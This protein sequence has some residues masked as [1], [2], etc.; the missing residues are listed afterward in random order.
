MR[1]AD[2]G[3]IRFRQLLTSLFIL[4]SLSIVMPGKVIERIPIPSSSAGTE[5]FLAVHRW[6]PSKPSTN[7]GG[8]LYIQAALHA[9]ETPGILVAQQLIS[10]LDAADARG[11]IARE[12]IIVPFANPIGL[13]QNILGSHIGVGIILPA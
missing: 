6:T 3:T 8:S 1:G 4:A 5:R 13:S 2:L 11:E 9:D 12:I 7:H 10:L